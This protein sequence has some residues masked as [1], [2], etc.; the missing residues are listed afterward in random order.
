M[1]VK[2]L[3]TGITDAKRDGEYI[4]SPYDQR[5]RWKRS[6]GSETIYSGKV[7]GIGVT[8]CPDVP[9]VPGFLIE[10]SQ[11]NGSIGL[12]SIQG[13]AEI[14]RRRELQLVHRRTR[15]ATPHESRINGYSGRIVSR[16]EQLRDRIP[17]DEYADHPE[18]EVNVTM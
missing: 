2:H 3:R 1:R 15:N 16:Q 9:E 10:D 7:P 11:L 18:T 6:A 13:T 5:G 12:E 17:D 4:P 8:D 14:D